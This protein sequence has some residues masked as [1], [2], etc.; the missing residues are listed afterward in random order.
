[1]IEKLELF[2]DKICDCSSIDIIRVINYS[3]LRLLTVNYQKNIDRN[4]YYI[5]M[6]SKRVQSGIYEVQYE[7]I[8]EF[9]HICEQSG[10]KPVFMKGIFLAVEL[11]DEMG[12][13]ACGDIDILI[14]ASHFKEYDNI[15]KGLGYECDGSES[16]VERY[17][18]VQ[19][20]KKRDDKKV[21]EFVL[22]ILVNYSMK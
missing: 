19:G 3:H 14:E 1:M 18:Q 13:R 4:Y 6:V 11:Y 22:M 16:R 2:L 15:F 17:V 5:S 12:A 20:K 7:A 21:W 9:L 10:L 8:Q